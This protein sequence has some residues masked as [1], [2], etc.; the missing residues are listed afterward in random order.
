MSAADRVDTFFH[1]APAGEIAGNQP[2]LSE[3]EVAGE[4]V[5]Q[6]RLAQ[7]GQSGELSFMAPH[8]KSS[9][10]GGAAICR[11]EAVL[12]RAVHFQPLLAAEQAVDLAVAERANA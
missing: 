12:R 1:R 7:G 11:G 8:A 3:A 4:R 5:A 2:V 10:R 9:C 6:K